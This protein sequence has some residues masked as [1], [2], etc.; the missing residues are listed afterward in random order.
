MPSGYVDYTHT[1]Y[2]KFTEVANVRTKARL[3]VYALVLVATFGVGAGL[4]RAVGPI[5]A[6][7]NAPTHGPVSGHSTHDGKPAA[8]TGTGGG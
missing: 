6:E 4:G 1:G 5:G 7:T 2:Q 3:G 8:G